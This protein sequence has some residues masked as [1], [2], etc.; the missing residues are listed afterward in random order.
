MRV[1]YQ[2]SS[3]SF[4]STVGGKENRGRKKQKKKPERS[5]GKHRK[6]ATRR[7]RKDMSSVLA[8]AEEAA[9][10]HIM[11]QTGKIALDDVVINRSMPFPLQS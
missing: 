4:N 11:E 2:V 6:K 8:G 1:D 7:S 5:K 3:V 9:A 10:K